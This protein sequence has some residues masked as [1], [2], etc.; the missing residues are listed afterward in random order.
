MSLEERVSQIEQRLEALEQQRFRLPEVGQQQ[1][2][3]HIQ[4]LEERIASET[5]ARRK[6]RLQR[7]LDRLRQINETS[8]T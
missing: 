7:H 6:E 1:L 3:G 8:S 4:R 5:D 2:E